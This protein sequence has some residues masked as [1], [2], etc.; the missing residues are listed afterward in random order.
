[1]SVK[2]VI[3]KDE[4]IKLVNQPYISKSGIKFTYNYNENG[5]DLI[6][7]SKRYFKN[8]LGKEDR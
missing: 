5:E 4:F 3:T 7:V 8:I 2:Q 1:M 6:E